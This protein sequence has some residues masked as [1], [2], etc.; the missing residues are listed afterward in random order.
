MER[1]DKRLSM[2][3]AAR[4]VEDGCRLA[5]GGFSIYQHPMSFTRE[6]VRQGR[7]NL[8]I[9]GSANGPEVDLL[10][11]A[12][13]VS[14][15][16]SSYVGLERFGL[17]Q[18]FRR[19][20]EEGHVVMI[21]YSE[22]L[23]FDRFRASQDGWPFVPCFYLGGTDIVRRNPDI[24]ESK[25]PITGRTFHAVPSAEPDVVVIH[26]S[27]ADKYGNVYVPQ[28]R[29]LPQSLDITMARSAETIIVTAER[30]V[31]TEILARSPELVEIPSYR[32]T[33]VVESPWGAHPC[34]ALDY[35][36]I[37]EDHFRTYAAAGRT[38]KEFKK[39]LDRYIHQV[40]GNE[41]YLREVGGDFERLVV[42]QQLPQ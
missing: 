7:R 39:Y 37:D 29:Q 20:V 35:Y 33:C 2:S 15:V 14:R 36:T 22:V 26:A 12:G 1:K 8:T 32:T 17:A 40:D 38:E 18:N 21:D 13:A 11:G 34:S 42:G 24:K 41:G 27:A 10:T 3:D 25:C 30:I 4:L 16:E 28:R 23:S 9:V 19:K 5:L 31:D 6:L